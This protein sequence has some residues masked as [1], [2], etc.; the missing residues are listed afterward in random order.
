MRDTT[1]LVTGGAGYVG[2]HVVRELLRAGSRVIVYDN[3]STG[4][5]R[6]INPQQG[7]DAFIEGDVR[8]VDL[9]SQVMREHRVTAAVHLAA[10]SLVGESMRNPSP[11]FENNMVGAVRLL[12]AMR[13]CRVRNI[14]FSSSAAVY[15]EPE[16]VP[17][18]EQHPCRPVNPYGETK[19]FIERMMAWHGRAHGLRCISLRYFNAAGADEAA[20]IGEDHNPETHLIPILL[21]TALGLAPKAF[22]YGTDYPTRDGS[23]VR[24]FVHVSDLARAHV[25]AL[26]SLE[27]GRSFAG[28]INLGTSSGNTVLEVLRA[29]EEVVGK[30]IPVEMAPR[31]EGDPAVLVAS[32]SL[33]VEVLGWWARHTSIRDIVASAW[34]WHRKELGEKCAKDSGGC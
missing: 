9:L 20:D 12:E 21:K 29:C 28:A 30:R 2:S 19:L 33:A 27:Q 34:R 16:A 14:V 18:E 3:L 25:L 32:T 31:R 6:L 10:S 8:D 7:I 22:I 5:R 17:I 11:T 23:C 4:H 26:D 13:R 1:V 24:D 15:G